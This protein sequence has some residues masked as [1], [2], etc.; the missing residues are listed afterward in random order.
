MLLG[1]DVFLKFVIHT[2]ELNNIPNT[3]HELILHA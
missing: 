1:F 3:S 2:T